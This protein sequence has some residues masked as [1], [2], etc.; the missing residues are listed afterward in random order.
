MSKC[1]LKEM[2]ARLTKIRKVL[3]L[4]Q[5][6]LSGLMGLTDATISSIENGKGKKG[7]PSTFLYELANKLNVNLNY[8]ILG[9]E[10]MF[11]HAVIPNKK[12]LTC[13]GT[14]KEREIE[15]NNEQEK[16]ESGNFDLPVIDI[17]TIKGDEALEIY[18]LYLRHSQYVRNHALADFYKFYQRDKE[19]IEKDIK[20]D[21]PLCAKHWQENIQGEKKNDDTKEKA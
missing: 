13:P 9:V 11:R 5:K 16:K 17:E 20:G 19:L 14:Q 8:F 3:K 2:G 7:P 4:K 6:T 12:D 10:D 15:S 18:I 1:N 21:N